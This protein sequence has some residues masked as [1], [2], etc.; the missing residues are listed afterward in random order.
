MVSANLF[1]PS[2]FILKLQ[3]LVFLEKI[4]PLPDDSGK[5]KKKKSPQECS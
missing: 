4:R 1:D 5:R 3:Y 2:F